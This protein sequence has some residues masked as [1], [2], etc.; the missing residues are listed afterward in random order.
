MQ[1]HERCW[2]LRNEETCKHYFLGVIRTATGTFQLRF[3]Y[4]NIGTIPYDRHPVLFAYGP[5]AVELAMEQANSLKEHDGCR[6]AP[7]SDIKRPVPEWFETVL[8]RK[9]FPVSARML[10][11]GAKWDF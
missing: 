11:R 4:G 9:G 7:V 10:R 8:Q 1:R 2:Y 6:L 3:A 5:D